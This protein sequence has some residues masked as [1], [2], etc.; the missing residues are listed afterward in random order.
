MCGWSCTPRPLFLRKFS[1]RIGRAWVVRTWSRPGRCVCRQV[2]GG[3]VHRF[4]IMTGAVARGARYSVLGTRK[5]LGGW[6]LGRGESL[7]HGRSTF[8]TAS[9][10]AAMAQPNV[11]LA[12]FEE[13]TSPVPRL[14]SQRG[15]PESKPRVSQETNCFAWLLHSMKSKKNGAGGPSCRLALPPLEVLKP[16]GVPVGNRSFRAGWR[17][18]DGRL[19]RVD[20]VHGPSDRPWRVARGGRSPCGPPRAGGLK[21]N[22]PAGQGP[23]GAFE[24]RP[25]TT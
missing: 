11:E 17:G 18:V 9:H 2:D 19:S 8:V 16:H 21:Q 24:P 22:A 5:C 12:H 3:C 25:S 10:F 6:G 7:F 20:R 15:A 1:R 4:S 23:A 13:V 14:Q